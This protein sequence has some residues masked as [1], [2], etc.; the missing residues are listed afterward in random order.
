[1]SHQRPADETQE[2]EVP[3]AV[4]AQLDSVGVVSEV[5]APEVTASEASADVAGSALLRFALPSM[6]ALGSL[7]ALEYLRYR[8]Q[9][10]HMFEP[11][12]Y[13]EGD[14]HPERSG[15]EVVDVDF[16]SGDGTRLNGW[17]IEASPTPSRL[18]PMTVVYCH[19]NSG[20]IAERVE[21]Y[22]HLRRLGVNIFA[23]D[24]RGYGRSS[25]EPSEDGVCADARAAI[26]HANGVLGVPYSRLIL[27]GHSLGGAIAIDTARRRPRIAGLVV[28]SSFTQN[29]DMA[30][31]FYPDLPVHWITRNGFRSIDKVPE[32]LMP[33]LFIH[34][35]ADKKVPFSQGQALFAAAAEPKA[36][37]P[38][39]RADHNDVHQ[40][41]GLRYFSR[42][43]RFGR[44]ARR[45]GLA[46]ASPGENEGASGSDAGV[47]A[48][49]SIAGR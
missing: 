9:R 16:T 13:P 42:L 35:A 47:G 24:Y 5:G 11:T 28:Q 33:K 22:K 27:F 12:R 37:L 26:D 46:A 8:F 10:R 36:W 1:M 14:W 43:V 15:L 39:A 40:W 34:G 41:G 20:S 32:L 4:A 49:P 45:H 31:H 44:E 25:G 17:W 21:I 30:R 2:I 29:L 19:G 6:A 7:G 23:F 3:E 38:I 18:E 48:P